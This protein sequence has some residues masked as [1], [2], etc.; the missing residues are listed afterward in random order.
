MATTLPVRP[1]A[2]MSS[3]GKELQEALSAEMQIMQEETLVGDEMRDKLFKS[4]RAVFKNTGKI[5]FA[6]RTGIT[7]GV[8]ALIAENSSLVNG[9]LEQINNDPIQ[10]SGQLGNSIQSFTE[11]RMMQSF[12]D[13]GKLAGPSAL[14]PCNDDEY[15]GAALGFAQELSRYA[16]GRAIENDTNSISICKQVIMQ[17]NEK[18]LEFDF[19]NGPLRRKYDGLK[20]ALKNLEQITYELSLIS[21]KAGDAEEPP[22]KKVRSEGS[23]EAAGSDATSDEEKLV[24][25]EEIDAIKVRMDEYDKLRE[26]V[27]KDSR[28][29]QK[30]AKQAIFSVHRG[31]LGAA[32]KQLDDALEKASV[33]MEVS[34]SFRGVQEEGYYSLLVQI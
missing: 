7:D 14:Q 17:L 33:I 18:M 24:P 5:Q 1:S 26:G 30:L 15:M 22:S 8:D 20:Y 13:T 12:F 4:S 2:V 11:T 23:E 3:F 9:L 29:V 25:V 19:R 21:E 16:V 28:D 6:V 32:K 27:I 10:R 31:N 34:L